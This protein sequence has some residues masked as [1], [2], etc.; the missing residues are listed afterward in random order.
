MDA[1]LGEGVSCAGG[2]GGGGATGVC[3]VVGGVDGEVVEAQDLQVSLFLHLP[4]QCGVP[5]V[6]DGV[7]C[8]EDQTQQLLLASS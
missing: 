1:D 5:V 3:R 4:L 2:S 7:I 6:F 8:P